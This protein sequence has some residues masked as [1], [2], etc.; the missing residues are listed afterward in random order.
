MQHSPVGISGQEIA[1]PETGGASDL[2][3]HETENGPWAP[4]FQIDPTVEVFYIFESLEMELMFRKKFESKRT[5][6]QI[7]P[8]D[9]GGAC[10]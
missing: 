10:V 3:K 5:Q 6:G 2:D 8:P 9:T 7:T 4:N 1:R